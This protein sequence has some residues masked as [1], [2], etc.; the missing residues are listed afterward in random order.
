MPVLAN[1][2]FMLER[3]VLRCHGRGSRRRR[4]GQHR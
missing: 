4:S 3:R 2:F 1:S